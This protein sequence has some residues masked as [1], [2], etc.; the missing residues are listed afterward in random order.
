[1]FG[2]VGTQKPPSQEAHSFLTRNAS[3]EENDALSVLA[4][5]NMLDIAI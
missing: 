4:K 2:S 3:H 1:M 5:T